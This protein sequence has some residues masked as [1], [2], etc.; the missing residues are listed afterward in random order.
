[1][2]AAK[3]QSHLKEVPYPAKAFKNKIKYYTNKDKYPNFTNFFMPKTNN[4]NLSN[5]KRKELK[6]KL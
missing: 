2:K 3:T 1:M 5:E 4:S 6:M